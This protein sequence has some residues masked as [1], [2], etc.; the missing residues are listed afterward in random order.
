M[1]ER[2]GGEDSS[3]SGMVYALHTRVEFTFNY[4]RI[5][6]NSFRHV[7]SHKSYIDLII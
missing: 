7:L 5:P 3:S 2:G 6:H 1:V 4:Q